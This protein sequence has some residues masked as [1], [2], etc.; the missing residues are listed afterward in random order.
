MSGYGPMASMANTGTSILSSLFSKDIGD[1]VGKTFDNPLIG[2][3]AGIAIPALLAGGTG[4][5]LGGKYGWGNMLPA[6]IMSLMAQMGGGEEG[7]Q[8]APASMGP[9][10]GENKSVNTGINS[11]TYDPNDP[12]SVMKQSISEAATGKVGGCY[13]YSSATTKNS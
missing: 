9:G 7:G 12:T 13:T 3:I 2:K 6:G 5:A 4:A 11:T 10:M 8:A 1:Y